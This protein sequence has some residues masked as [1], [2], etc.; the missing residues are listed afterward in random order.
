MA[1]RH[2]MRGSI[3]IE[4]DGVSTTLNVDLKKEPI[5]VG[6][7]S[8]EGFFDAQQWGLIMGN[9]VAVKSTTGGCTAS[10]SVSG[11]LTLTFDTAP[12]AGITRT[13]LLLYF[14]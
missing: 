9:I 12:P 11:V 14:S 7:V 10:L 6:S 1:L 3:G 8:N 13:L 4:A 5:I 2:I